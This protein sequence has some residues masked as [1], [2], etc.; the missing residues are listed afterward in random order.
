VVDVEDF[1]ADAVQG[2]GEDVAQSRDDFAA[3]DGAGV[4]G[5]TAQVADEVAGQALKVTERAQVVA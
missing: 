5:D 1:L 4:P 2:V 3:E